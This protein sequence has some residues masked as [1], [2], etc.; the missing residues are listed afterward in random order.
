RQ[1]VE[2]ELYSARRAIEERLAATP[3]NVF[4]ALRETMMRR[5][6]DLDLPDA[7]MPMLAPTSV[8]VP[9]EDSIALDL[10]SPGPL[11]GWSR[12]RTP[13]EHAA[14]LERMM[15]EEF[16]PAVDEVI[17]L[18]SAELQRETG[19]M[20]DRATA[21]AVAVIDALRGQSETYIARAKQLLDAREARPQNE[22]NQAERLDMLRERL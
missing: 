16:M 2:S 17:R 9:I 8:R 10:A 1:R 22:E 4:P 14:E 7:P 6:P 11:L 18:A 20:S 3:H 12:S 19:S 15:V 5:A 13:E 21:I